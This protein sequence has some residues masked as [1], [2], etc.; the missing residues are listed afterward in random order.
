M[1]ERRA[2][3]SI[4]MA[5]AGCVLLLSTAVHAID[6]PKPAA[7]PPPQA[8][9]PPAKVEVTPTYLQTP[10]DFHALN[11]VRDCRRLRTLWS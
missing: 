7:A 2:E 11:C 6:A 1:S 9:P 10:C 3:F 4:A 5:A 8:A